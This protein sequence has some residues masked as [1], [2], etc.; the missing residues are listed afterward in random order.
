MFG[1]WRRLA[2]SSGSGISPRSSGGMLR[3][4]VFFACSAARLT[5]SLPLRPGVCSGCWAGESAA[6]AASPGVSEGVFFGC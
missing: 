6:A 1:P 3:C 2:V 4:A 5:A